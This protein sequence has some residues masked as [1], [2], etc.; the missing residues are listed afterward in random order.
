MWDMVSPS[1]FSCKARIMHMTNTYH[2]PYL[3]R[4]HIRPQQL[5]W[6]IIFINKYQ[7]NWNSWH[8]ADTIFRETCFISSLIFQLS[9][10]PKH[11]IGSYSSLVHIMFWCWT[12]DKP[13]PKPMIIPSART[14]WVNT[15]RP[16]QEGR[17]SGRW[18]FQAHFL[19]LNFFNFV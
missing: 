1:D 4:I 16:R 7:P 6:S 5:F 2:G 18:H 13:L 11:P 17:H 3:Q 9:L 8:F 14:Q 12:C 19:E 10:F 15:L